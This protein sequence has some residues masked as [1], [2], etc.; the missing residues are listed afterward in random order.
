ME[1]ER[2]RRSGPMFLAPVVRIW[3]SSA[4]WAPL[5][6]GPRPVALVQTALQVFRGGAKPARKL[7]GVVQEPS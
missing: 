5:H 4:A 7:E 1:S 3:A 2:T 6:P